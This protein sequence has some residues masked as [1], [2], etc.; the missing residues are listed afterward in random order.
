MATAAIPQGI[1]AVLLDLDGVLY[2]GNEAIP[3]APAAVARLKQQGLKLAGVTN[4]TTTSRRRIHE[5]LAR[6]GIP[7]EQAEIFTP[8]A[9]ARRLIGPRRAR[10]FIREELREDFAGIREDETQAEVVVMGDVGGAGY[11]PELLREVFLAVL[12]GAELIALHK[13]RFWKK[14][15]GLHLDLGAFVAA[16]EYATNRKAVIAGKPSRDFFRGI[17]ASL[18][19]KP[20]R[21]LMVGDDIESDILGA[22]EAGLKTALVH[23]GKYRADFAEEIMRAHGFRPD[24]EPDSIAA[25]SV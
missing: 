5:K 2:V 4:T 6:L 12:D 21:A 23:T 13:N 20:A 8:A 22:H 16:V 9:V 10:L 11:P 3:G 1:Q 24:L 7:L 25:L 18:G 17:C 15:D 14:P 19:V